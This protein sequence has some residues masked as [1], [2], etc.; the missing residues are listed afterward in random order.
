MSANLAKVAEVLSARLKPLAPVTLDRDEKAGLFRVF[1]DGQPL[2]RV[3]DRDQ[4]EGEII[5]A[6]MSVLEPIAA[7]MPGAIAG[8]APPQTP[9]RRGPPVLAQPSTREPDELLEGGERLGIS[10]SRRE[11]ELRSGG[12]IALEADVNL[13][14]L[15]DE[16]RHFL[17]ELSDRLS[18][19][20][21]QED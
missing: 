20:E 9:P 7:S 11:I 1:G 13:F 12:T 17:F 16:D 21:D 14:T 10:T 18:A 4:S 15:S 2:T 3:V 5:E 6:A 19:Y 8:Y